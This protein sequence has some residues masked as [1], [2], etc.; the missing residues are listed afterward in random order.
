VQ[1]ET[2]PTTSHTYGI[3]G[4]Y[5]I[6]LTVTNTSGTST[7][8]TF[9]GQ[10]VSNNGGPSAELQEQVTIF[11]EIPAPSKFNGKPKIY[12][13][14]GR[15]FLRTKCKESPSSSSSRIIRYEIFAHTQKIATIPAKH[16]LKK[17]LRLH[18]QHFPHHRLSKHYR[19][20]LQ[21]K[22]RIRAV[23]S[24]GQASIFTP[25]HISTRALKSLLFRSHH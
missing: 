7:T 11:F 8:Q 2:S 15:L 6:T 9:T 21:S 14:S 20:Y 17:T 25:L 12:K 1:T 4:T 22:Y 23:D 3:N 10:T 18:P 24:V 19:H 5:T 13:K 16:H